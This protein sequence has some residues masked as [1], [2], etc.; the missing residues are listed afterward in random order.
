MLN[1]H[2]ELVEI[3]SSY[4]HADTIAFIQKYKAHIEND[5]HCSSWGQKL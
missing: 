4:I 3:D 1:V 5:G 2:K